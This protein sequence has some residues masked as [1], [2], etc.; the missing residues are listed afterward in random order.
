MAL[1][2]DSEGRLTTDCKTQKLGR[3]APGLFSSD[4]IR[5]V[6]HAQHLCRAYRK[7]VHATLAGE[8]LP[9][10]PIEPTRPLPL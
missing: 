6:E 1:P 5:R 9:E 8:V 10:G 7:Y 4:F 2:E 3:L